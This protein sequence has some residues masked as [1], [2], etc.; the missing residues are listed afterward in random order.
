MSESVH[1]RERSGRERCA[2]C[3]EEFSLETGERVAC[4]GC[5]TPHHGECFALNRR[6]S[7]L[8]CGQAFAR[9]ADGHSVAANTLAAPR[10]AVSHRRYLRF[11][12][13]VVVVA[14]A[15]ATL[16][17]ALFPGQR[18]IGLVALVLGLPLALGLPLGL[19]HSDG[20]PPLIDQDEPPDHPVPWAR[21]LPPAHGIE[22]AQAAIATLSRRASGELP[23]PSGPTAP[24]PSCGRSLEG[25]ADLRF[26]YHCGASLS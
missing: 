11:A 4:A 25:T 24:C 1:A 17:T 10:D 20:T 18:E 22:A 9:L 8:G 15:V 12:L 7:A 14:L 2:Y 16:L 19:L 21:T 26:C 3:H 23:E 13:G 5:G 6:C